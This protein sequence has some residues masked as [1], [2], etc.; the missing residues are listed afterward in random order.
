M[1]PNGRYL[2]VYVFNYC[3]LTA[4]FYYIFFMS[5]AENGNKNVST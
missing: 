3:Q 4:D 2:A 1:Y 5:K